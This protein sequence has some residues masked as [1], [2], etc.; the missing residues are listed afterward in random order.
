M[1]GQSTY[2]AMCV[3]RG[4]VSARRLL[5]KPR[6][7]TRLHVG[8]STSTSFTL[9]LRPVSCLFSVVF[10]APNLQTLRQINALCLL[11]ER[12]LLLVKSLNSWAKVGYRLPLPDEVTTTG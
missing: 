3:P 5:R 8:L 1:R 9:F 11:W 10:L 2:W 12:D 7:A 6:P 4:V